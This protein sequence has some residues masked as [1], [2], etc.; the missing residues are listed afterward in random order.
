[1]IQL[2]DALRRGINGRERKRN[3]IAALRTAACPFASTQASFTPF[4]N[5]KRRRQWTSPHACA[6]NWDPRPAHKPT[7]I[8]VGDQILCEEIFQSSH[9]SFLGG[10]DKSLQK[11]PVL[12]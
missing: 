1:M 2:I 10:S 3:V 8:R 7:A 9:V 5:V 11:T 6:R 12:A 4:R